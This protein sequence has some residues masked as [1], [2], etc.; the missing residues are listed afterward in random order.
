[1]PQGIDRTYIELLKF[2]S[3]WNR[4]TT[5]N[6]GAQCNTFGV[7]SFRADYV[8]SLTNYELRELI[9][10]ELGHGYLFATE[11]PSYAER[12]T[13]NVHLDVYELI[14]QW[15]FDGSMV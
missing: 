12:D 15:G 2:K 5:G 10:H 1:M 11:G 7:I 3:D 6:A 9:A 13:L 14:T 8:D 4:G